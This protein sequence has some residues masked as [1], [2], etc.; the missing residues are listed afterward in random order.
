M[1]IQ[2]WINK[3]CKNLSGKTI[4]ITGSTGGLAKVFTRQLASLGANFI[5]ANRN[6]EK[7]LKQKQALINEFPN[8]KIEIMIVDMFDINSV[9][10]FVCKLKQTHV[11]ILILNSAVYNVPRQTSSAGFDNVFQINFVSPYYIARQMMPSLR[12]I[13]DSKVV[14]LGSIAHNYSKIDYNDSQKQKTQKCNI[15]YG[16]SKRFLMFSMQKLFSDSHVNLAIVHPGITLTNM[17]SHYPRA[18]NWLVK[19]GIKAF[20]PKPSKASLS[21]LFGVFNKTEQNEWIGPSKFNVWGL[22]KKQKLNTCSNL[23]QEQIFEIA[24]SIYKEISS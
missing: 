13:K 12:K 20:F 4:C 14:V 15:I 10:L 1:K 19:I 11:D 18:I 5:L 23:E 24:E 9:K 2:T 8:I 7:S 6:K 22:P 21:V 17:T 16:N 3:N